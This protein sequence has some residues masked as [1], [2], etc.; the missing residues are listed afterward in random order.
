MKNTYTFNYLLGWTCLTLIAIMIT[1]ACIYPF[2]E[3]QVQSV[4]RAF[5]SQY[6]SWQYAPPGR[7]DSEHRWVDNCNEAELFHKAYAVI[8]EGYSTDSTT[9]CV[10]CDE[11][12][13]CPEKFNSCQ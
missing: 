13:E 11:L 9:W 7:V 2:R 1:T 10:V 12:P 3:G 6:T 8:W 4:C 5:P